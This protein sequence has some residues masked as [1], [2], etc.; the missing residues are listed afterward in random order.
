MIYLKRILFGLAWL[1][2]RSLNCLLMLPTFAVIL[3]I[4]LPIYYIKN[5]TICGFEDKIEDYGQPIWDWINK[6]DPDE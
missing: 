3:V 1:P 4:V 2:Y 5:G 6:F